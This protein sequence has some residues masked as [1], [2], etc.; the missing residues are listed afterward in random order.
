MGQ[1][2]VVQICNPDIDLEIV[3]RA[4]NLLGS[5]GQHAERDIRVAGMKWRGKARNHG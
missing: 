1:R 5:L 2:L 3:E 4:L